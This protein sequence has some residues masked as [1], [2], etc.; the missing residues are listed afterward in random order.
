MNTTTTTSGRGA[1]KG[2]QN[3]AKDESLDHV[4]RLRVAGPEKGAWKRCADKEGLS[5]AEWTRRNNNLA[6]AG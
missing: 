4:L 3:A 6:A 2:N 5:L 1:P